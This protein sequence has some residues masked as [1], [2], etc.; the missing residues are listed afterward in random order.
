MP[1]PATRPTRRRWRSALAALAAL[2]MG[3]ALLVGAHQASAAPTGPDP[4][5]A[6][7]YLTARPS[8][9]TVTT[10]TRSACGRPTGG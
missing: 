4:Q 1:V 2:G 8:W 3:S 7:A 10:T 5:K 9:S 6:V